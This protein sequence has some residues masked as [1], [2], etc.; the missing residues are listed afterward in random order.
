MQKLRKF[1]IG[2]QTFEQIVKDGWL[3]ADK[4]AI[5]H[6]LAMMHKYV[7][8]SRPRRFGKSLLVS[9]FQSYF[10]GRADLF[11]GLAAETLVEE[12][13]A[14]PVFRFDMSTVKSRDLATLKSNI[15]G[16]IAREEAKYGLVPDVGK[17]FTAR[18]ANLFEAA[19][20]KTGQGVVLLID[21]YD[22]PLLE[23]MREGDDELRDQVRQILRAFYS[24]IKSSDALI[25]FGFITGI[26]KF[27]QL[28]IFSEINNLDKMTLD[29]SVAALCGITEG[30]LHTVFGSDVES[31]AAANGM[32]VDAAFAK[33]KA[34]YDGY[35]FSEGGADVYNPFSLLCALSKR[36]FGD[37]WFDSG[38]PI[39]LVDALRRFRK[40]PT[41]LAPCLCEAGDFDAP[42]ETMRSPIPL[43]FQSGYL[44][45]KDYDARRGAF[46]LDFP[47][48]EVRKG[49]C[50]ALL[51][52]WL[53]RPGE[54]RAVP[55]FDLMDLLEQ[56]RIDELMVWMKA[57][58]AGIPY[59]LTYSCEQYYHLVFFLVFNLLGA[60]MDAEVRFAKGRAD[61]VVRTDTHVY[62][63]EF[64]YEGSADEA[65]AQIDAKGYL[66]PFAAEGRTLVKIGASFSS[67]TKTLA[68]WKT[69]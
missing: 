52:N 27:S 10:E 62:V 46:T 60:R 23:V 49:L 15:N 7:F 6:E 45:I 44:T 22:A 65:L 21:E 2:V 48:Q 36:K 38:T 53:E 68:D 1:P 64:K 55:L 17:S 3:Y 66:V 42:C 58:F 28:S 8:L 20:A 9:T 63:F 18:V 25:R 35:R 30:E 26:T 19:H 14:H 59:D 56:D 4:T 16:L 47:N 32:T 5:V 69:V 12:W 29:D 61:A 34:R 31:L 37:Y 24:P 13:V 33:L 43:F 50:G 11:K 57:Y 51:P 40:L 39:F 67:E 54:A 41:D